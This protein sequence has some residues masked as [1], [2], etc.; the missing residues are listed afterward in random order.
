MKGLILILL[1]LSLFGQVSGT[2]SSS[3]MSSVSWASDTGPVAVRISEMANSAGASQTDISAYIGGTVTSGLIENQK[4]DTLFE[5]GSDLSVMAVEEELD[6]VTQNLGNPINIPW[7][8]GTINGQVVSA[9]RPAVPYTYNV[10]ST[11]WWGIFGTSTTTVKNT[12]QNSIAKWEAVIPASKTGVNSAVGV[13]GGYPAMGNGVST[14]AFGSLPRGVLAINNQNVLP[15]QANGFWGSSESDITLSQNYYWRDNGLLDYYAPYNGNMIHYQSDDGSRSLDWTL[16]HELGHSY[17]LTD[18][19]HPGSIMGPYVP[20]VN[21]NY[22]ASID[23]DTKNLV[24][25]V[26]SIQ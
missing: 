19:D 21:R 18:R 14:I 10:I 5:D 2:G 20:Q 11:P 25:L 3:S 26:W 23:Q 22:P 6:P 17:G 12:M 13:V 1:A 4:I 7:T 8:Y 16:T 15:R 24:G 9:I